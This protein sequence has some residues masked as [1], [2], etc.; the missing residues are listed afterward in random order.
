M[1][2]DD[3]ASDDEYIYGSGSLLGAS[4]SDN[5]S[6]SS[7]IGNQPQSSSKKRKGN[8][9]DKPSSVEVVSSS[10]KRRK[11]KK[12]DA[13]VSSKSLLILAGRGIALDSAESQ[14]KFINTLYSHSM[15]MNGNN[16]AETFSFTPEH[17]Y[18]TPLGTDEKIKQ[19]QHKKLDAFLKGPVTSTKRLKNWKHECSP[20]V[21]I[22]T[23]SAR[24]SV[25]L[26]KELSSMK[27]PV[28]KLFAKHFTVEEQVEMLKGAVKGSGGGGGKK[29]SDRRYSI[30]V[31]TPGRLLAL[32]QHGRNEEGSDGLGALRLN[33]TEVV[34]F[35]THEDSKGFNVCTL[36]DTSSDL[37]DFLKEGVVPQ[38]ERKKSNMKIAMF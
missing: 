36:K 25:E 33:H 19:F 14:V 22:V 17:F 16:E 20:M 26:M 11:K 38:L 9:T 2:G 7:E 5:D 18:T 10:K 29:R 23:L 8:N 4:F 37:M 34:V 31:G 24:R 27:L 1:G 30:A 6:V 12:D 13:P 32:L 15:K 3:L 28:A 21:I 35:D